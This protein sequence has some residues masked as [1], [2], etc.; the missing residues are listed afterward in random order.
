MKRHKNAYKWSKDYKRLRYLL[1]NGY[2]VV[3]LADY[4][5]YKDGS[6]KDRD[7]CKGTHFVCDGNHKYDCYQISS[8]GFG[9]VNHYDWE[10]DFRSFDD[11]CV[12]MNI[13]FIDI[14]SV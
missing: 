1:D 9:Y 12:E 2:M 4:D 7:I 14:E 11:V 6:P 5:F 8:R 10:S 13:E 3:C